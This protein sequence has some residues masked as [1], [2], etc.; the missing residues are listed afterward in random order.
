M[1][2]IPSKP[3][4]KYE[5]NLKEFAAL[6]GVSM[7]TITDWHKEKGLPPPEKPTKNSAYYDLEIYIPW[8]RE[9]IW[10]P[11]TNATARKKEADAAI[12]EMERDVMAGVLVDALA[13]QRSWE[14][15]LARFR[16]NIRGFPARLVPLLEEASTEREKL[17]IGQREI[18]S[19][20]RDLVAK[21]EA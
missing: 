10:K 6:C 11:A 21:E 17:A 16:T 14:D 8:M 15:A 13:V 19:V 20:L 5:M 3:L 2:A 18:D 9:N 1:V 7:T 12:A 4:R